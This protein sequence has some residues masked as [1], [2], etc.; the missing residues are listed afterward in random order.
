MVGFGREA[1]RERQEGG[2]DLGSDEMARG[3]LNSSALR[4]RSSDHERMEGGEARRDRKGW[5]HARSGGV[6]ELISS[7]SRNLDIIAPT[8][9]VAAP[10]APGQTLIHSHIIDRTPKTSTLRVPRDIFPS[11]TSLN[12]AMHAFHALVAQENFSLYPLLSL[13]LE[14][15]RSVLRTLHA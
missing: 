4:V 7:G 2:D 12:T 10:K 14:F 6:V 3:A 5:L 8:P 9:E 11:A 15:K 1:W 13:E